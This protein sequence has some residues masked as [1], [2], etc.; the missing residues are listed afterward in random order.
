MGWKINQGVYTS[1]VPIS[2]AAS[3]GPIVFFLKKDS[4]DG[5]KKR[6]SMHG[7]STSPNLIH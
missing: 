6:R 3:L 4:T 5:C 1:P 2:S 7:K